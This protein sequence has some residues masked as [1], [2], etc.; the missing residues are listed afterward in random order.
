MLK[1][2]WQVDFNVLCLAH[3]K[4]AAEQ[5]C[6]D[7][8]RSRLKIGSIVSL[9]G[10]SCL[11]RLSNGW[12]YFILRCDCDNRHSFLSEHFFQLAGP[13]PRR[14]V[15]ARAVVRK[16]KVGVRRYRQRV[17]LGAH[18]FVPRFSQYVSFSA[19]VGKRRCFGLRSASGKRDDPVRLEDSRRG[20]VDDCKFSRGLADD[21]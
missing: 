9:T 15:V 4:A 5:P 21:P 3:C 14:W 6:F 2:A 18:A 1:Q 16:Y 8:P 12:S 11:S 17:E 10:D 13:S 7:N 20:D 19:A